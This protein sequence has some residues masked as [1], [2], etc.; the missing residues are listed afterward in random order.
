MQISGQRLFFP[1]NFQFL[2][3]LPQRF[4]LLVIA[5]GATNQNGSA[6]EVK[7]L[8]Q[9]LVIRSKVALK[10]GA[11]YELE[12]T[13]AIEFRIVAEKKSEI[14]DSSPRTEKTKT[15]VIPE[16]LLPLSGAT[17]PEML[18]VKILINE[19]TIQSPSIGKYLVDWNLELGFKGVFIARD[20]GEH[21]LFVTGKAASGPTVQALAEQLR[22]LGI[23]GVR[24][25]SEQTFQSLAT[26]A[27][28][29][30]G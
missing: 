12:K 11:R 1:K 26:G 16:N 15:T 10:E 24:N 20:S 9:S 25:V 30:Q 22:D 21:V 8:G 4:E 27:I 19:G 18:A 13:S 5:R 29:L 7:V 23:L 2:Q 28:D 6:F 3:R 14:D 17:L